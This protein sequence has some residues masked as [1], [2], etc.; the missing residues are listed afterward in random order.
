M[1]RKSVALPLF[2]LAVF[3]V[4]YVLFSSLVAAVGITLLIGMVW[5][6]W[7]DLRRSPARPGRTADATDF[8]VVA[9]SAAWWHGS[10]G[11]CSS[12]SFDGGGAGCDGG[13]AF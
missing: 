1:T 10:P 12:S 9:A 13:G 4:T 5:A 2:V 11:D 8:G 6:V 7:G 3:A